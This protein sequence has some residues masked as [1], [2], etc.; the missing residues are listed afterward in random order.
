MSQIIW[1]GKPF[2]SLSFGKNF[3]KAGRNFSGKITIF[4][5]GGGSKKLYRRIDYERKNV[6]QGSVERIEYD[7]NRTARIALIRWSNVKLEN[8]KINFNSYKNRN[9]YFSDQLKQKESVDTN[10]MQPEDQKF[11][12]QN[13]TKRP[14][15]LRNSRLGNVQNAQIGSKTASIRNLNSFDLWNSLNHPKSIPPSAPSVSFTDSN[16][17]KSFS[18]IAFSYILAWEDIQP[19]D[20]IYN[21]ES[22]TSKEISTKKNQFSVDLSH[23]E[24]MN[25]FNLNVA[26]SFLD[27]ND[28]PKELNSKALSVKQLYQKKGVSMPL[29]LVPL[30][31][32][33]YNI[34][35]QPGKGGQLVRAAGTCAQLVKKDEMNTSDLSVSSTSS[36][37]LIRMPSGQQQRLDSHCR[38]TI[39]TVSNATHA[40]RQLRKAGQKRWLGFRPVVRGV[41]MNPIDHPHGGGEGRTKGGRPSVSPWGKPSKCGFGSLNKFRRK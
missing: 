18:K 9:F 40:T 16:K 4:H 1:K 14:N 5:R 28:F 38:V 36:S 30:G 34:E 29:Y 39:G 24:I 7:P 20:Q 31:S 32:M 22:I 35:L 15:R 33:I 25:D 23:A 10:V 17:I 12:I 26:T 19:G 11:L 21:F 8:S 13:E 3:E 2:K 37:C 41:A 6:A 27:S